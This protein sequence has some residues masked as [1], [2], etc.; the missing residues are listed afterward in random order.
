[1]NNSD[2]ALANPHRTKLLSGGQI[3]LRRLSR[4]WSAAVILGI[5]QFL[6][7]GLNSA[8]VAKADTLNDH[9][10]VLDSNNKIIPWMPNPTAGYGE[11]VANAWDYFLNRVP[12]DPATGVSAY[13][14]QSYL[15]PDTQQVANWPHNPAGLYAMLIESALKYY[16]YSGDIAVMQKVEELATHHLDN[17]MTP[18]AWVWGGVPYASGDA[19]SLLY[20]GATYGDDS[21]SGDGRYYLEPDKIGELGYGWLLLYKFSGNSR[22][23]D[24]AIHAAD[25]LATKVRTGNSSQSPW[26]FRVHAQTGQIREDYCAHVVSPIELF[27]EL[28]RLKLG[29]TADYQ[30]ARQSVWTWMMTYPM[31]NNVWA[32]YFEDVP[33]Q[34]DLGNINQLNPMMLARYLMEHPENDANW[35]T[36]VRGLIAWVEKNF[37]APQYG[38]NAIKEQN[39]FPHVMGSHT[40]RYASINAMLYARTGDVV[41]KEKAYR[42][43]NW[44]TYM[45][46]S[47]GIVID[48]PTVNNQWFTDGYGDYIRHFMTGLHAIPEW[49]P[50]GETHI[51]GSSSIVKSVSYSPAEVDYITADA[52]STEVLRVAFVPSSVLIDGQLLSQRTDLAQ[53]GWTFDQ[54]T[55]VMRVRH[56]DGTS[57][58]INAANS[59]GLSG[60][61]DTYEDGAS[62]SSVWTLTS[63]PQ[64]SIHADASSVELGVKF[65]SDVNGFVTG[66]RFYKGGN[67]NNGTHIGNLWTSDGNL[68]ATAIFSSETASGWQQARFSTPVA[69]SANTVYVASYYAPNGHYAADTGYFAENGTDNAPLHMLRDGENGGNGVYSYGPSA[70]PVKTW[71]S[72]NYWV[73]VTFSKSLALPSGSNA[74][75][76]ST[77]INIDQVVSRD[78]Q[79]AVVTPLFSTSEPNALLLAFVASDGPAVTGGQTATVSGAGLN[80]TLVRRTN[81][82][83]GTSEVWSAYANTGLSNVSVQSVQSNEEYDQSLTVVSISG[84]GGVGTSAGASS[85]SGAP[86]VYLT[87]TKTNAWVFGVGNDWDNAID[88]TLGTAQTMM[89]QW[90]DTGMDDTFWV[91]R[92]LTRIAEANT[93]VT[94]NALAPTADRWNLSAVEV[95]PR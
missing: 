74:P 78:G 58:K 39:A 37:A 83:A 19:G 26:P 85:P 31:Q 65:K 25:V 4:V 9:A 55:G 17:G 47:N 60:G 15:S 2:C 12:N 52:A 45:A 30:N 95:V 24:A 5:L 49:A 90:V 77:G 62:E 20:Q 44:A 56:D 66:I 41:A 23:L 6:L 48:G 57:V 72:S 1:M 14:S 32:N 34:T 36:H 10:I 94:I 81:T 51:T 71:R 8:G 64:D 84:A 89:H 3:W 43:F 50:T 28:I 22:Y 92:S 86:S 53:P 76:T 59:D 79:G 46:R 75:A 73:D 13:F 35:E 93:T 63:V 87:T 91:Q 42:A 29:N 33:I 27:D 38:A 80:W 7:P 67:A 54:A 40:S 21:G 82:E 16:A 70:F 69:I 88:H 68:I 11:V 61:G 18:S